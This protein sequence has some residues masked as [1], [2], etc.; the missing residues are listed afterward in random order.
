MRIRINRNHITARLDPGTPAHRVERAARIVATRAVTTIGPVTGAVIT[1]GGPAYA[2]EDGEPLPADLV[3]RL[4]EIVERA[5]REVSAPEPWVR[6]GARAHGEATI[7]E[8]IEI[9]RDCGHARLAAML[10]EVVDRRDYDRLVEFSLGGGA[11]SAGIT[12]RAIEGPSIRGRALSEWRGSRCYS[13]ER[14]RGGW[15]VSFL[16]PRQSDPRELPD[17]RF[18]ARYISVDGR[19]VAV[20]PPCAPRNALRAPE[21]E[22]YPGQRC[23]RCGA[24]LRPPRRAAG[25]EGGGQES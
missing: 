25:A 11:V 14:V 16:L 3:Q 13:A 8:V 15:R 9:A 20:C 22:L 18:P 12:V 7:A 17:D 24:V 19:P 4:D 23:H 10:A 2:T 21:G 1:A 6:R 5:C